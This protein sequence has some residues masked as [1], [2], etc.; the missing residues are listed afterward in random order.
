[1]NSLKFAYYYKRNLEM[2]FK[3][4]LYVM[5]VCNNVLFIFRIDIRIHDDV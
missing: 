1:M 2:V 5:F 4:G 3:V